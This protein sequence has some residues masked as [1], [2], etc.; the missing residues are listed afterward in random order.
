MSF[1]GLDGEVGGVALEYYL[2]SP[3]VGIQQNHSLTYLSESSKESY[4]LIVLGG[5]DVLAG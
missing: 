2:V 4:R 3:D 1:H 5:E